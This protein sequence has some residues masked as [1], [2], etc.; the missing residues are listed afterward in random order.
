MAFISQGVN[1]PMEN[2]VALQDHGLFSES[3]FDFISWGPSLVSVT[4]CICIF[5]VSIMSS[6]DK[7]LEVSAISL[8]K[9]N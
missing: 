5:E 8:R 2:T 1:I 4:M 3:D 6:N 9:I 7:D